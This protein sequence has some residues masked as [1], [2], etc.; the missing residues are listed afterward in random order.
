MKCIF[1]NIRGITNASS[2]LTLKRLIN[3]NNP[4]LVF[5]AEP[6]MDFK[7]VP[8]NWLKRLNLKLFAMNERLDKHPNF[9]CFCKMDMNPSIIN[10]DDQHISFSIDSNNLVLGFSVVYAATN[11]IDRRRLWSSL[12]TLIIDTPWCFIGDF[13]AIIESGEYKGDSC[14]ASI[15]MKEFLSWS[16]SNH[17]VHV[18]TMGN[19]YTWNN[20]KKGKKLIE[21]RLDRA[22]CNFKWIG[23]CIKTSCHTLTKANSE[24]YPILLNFNFNDIKYISQFKFKSMWTNHSDCMEIVGET[25]NTR[26]YGCPMYILNK[27]LRILKSKLKDWNKN[28]FGKVQEKVK[29]TELNLMNIQQAIATKGYYDNLRIHEKNAQEEYNKALDFE[30]Q[31][32]KEKAIINWCTNGDR[33]TKFFHRY[34][35]IKRTTNLINAITINDVVHTHMDT[36]E[37]HFLNHF[38]QLFNKNVVMQDNGLV[39]GTIPNL[40]NK[41]TTK[42]LTS[43]PNEVEIKEAVMSIKKDGALGPDG[44][45]V[46][47]F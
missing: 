17:L 8:S 3:I 21:K 11:Y 28:H 20:C 9:W 40:I 35:A 29:E 47:V 1:W 10:Y 32:W 36:I 33:N 42:T 41:D 18:P 43:V 44:F 6:W 13:N 45:G 39:K 38:H 4:D 5:I 14:T 46:V 15:P 25:W 7:N 12:D 31:F 16:D 30:E 34:V 22:M 2:R 27:K 24:H 23:S 26:I 19:Q 37:K